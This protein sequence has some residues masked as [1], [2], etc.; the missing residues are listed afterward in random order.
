LT[1]GFWANTAIRIPFP[2]EAQKVRNTVYDLGLRKPVEDFELALNRAAE[3]AAKEAAPILVRAIMEMTLADAFSIL[4]G[5]DTAATNYLRKA[6]SAQLTN[7]F[8]PTVQ[9]A[10]KRV[11]LT[12]Y[13]QP[14]ASAYNTT[15]LLTGAKAVSPDLDAYVT[16]RALS[17]LF[18]L[19][20]Q[21]EMRIRKDPMARTTDLL[22]RVFAVQ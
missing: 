1:D 3:E 13:W 10:T 5:G 2:P 7:A 18:V 21:E 17:G 19:V 6:T 14:L 16:G 4:N 12:S 11:K 9:R 8:L 15:T 20:R 22:R